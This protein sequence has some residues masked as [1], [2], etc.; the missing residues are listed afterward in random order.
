MVTA[1]L[2]SCPAGCCCRGG[3]V[4][5]HAPCRRPPHSSIQQSRKL[6]ATHPEEVEGEEDYRDQHRVEETG[7]ACHEQVEGHDVDDDRTQDEQ[8]EIPRAGDGD[9]DSAEQFADLDEGHVTGRSQSGH[10][11]GH[12]RTLGNL[13]SWREIEQ[14]HHGSH[15][16]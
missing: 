12:G 5:S 13:R 2:I 15:D 7:A 9:E 10:E 8:S 1:T 14:D 11:T 16:K 3:S 4:I 6:L